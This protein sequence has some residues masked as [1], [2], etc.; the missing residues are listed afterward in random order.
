VKRLDAGGWGALV[1]CGLVTT[2]WY[3]AWGK[4][5]RCLSSFRGQLP[6]PSPCPPVHACFAPAAPCTALLPALELPHPHLSPATHFLALSLPGAAPL[7][8]SAPPPAAQPPLPSPAT[9]WPRPSTPASSTGWFPP[10]TARSTRWVGGRCGVVASSGRMHCTQQCCF[11]QPQYPDLP[12]LCS[13]FLCAAGSGE[14]AA[15]GQ[16]QRR[17]IGIL[18]IYGGC[19]K[20]AQDGWGQWL[21]TQEPFRC[22][23]GREAAPDL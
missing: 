5:R 16:Q 2:W 19:G 10:S 3:R 9:L 6:L 4:C 18:D 12:S 8:S 14:R 11:L 22:G 20:E 23:W 1:V 7:P 21:V 17:S 13:L 15:A